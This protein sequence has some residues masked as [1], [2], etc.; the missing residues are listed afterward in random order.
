MLILLPPSEGKTEASARRRPVD[1]AALSFAEL[2]PQR[3]AVADALSRASARA[4]ALTVL[5][6]GASLEHEVRSNI[7][8][9]TLPAAPAGEVYSGV[10]YDALDLT[11]LDAASR[12]RAN[13]T[14]LVISALW[15]AVRM[16]DRIPAYRLSMSVDL[17]GIGPLAQFWRPHLSAALADLAPR[18]V[19]V[20]CRSAPYQAAWPTPAPERSVQVRVVNADDR[21][22]VS[23]MAK[24]TRGLVARH[25]CLRAGRVPMTPEQLAS[26]VAESFEVGLSEPRSSRG[27]WILDVVQPRPQN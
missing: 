9:W 16:T 26:A 1:P 11:S 5:G 15:G 27:T 12:R 7:E 18:G 4:D 20:D 25:L 23:H 10:L 22:A 24:H 14:L 6:V 13:R 19:I 2:A 21:T 3:S 17:P 8:I